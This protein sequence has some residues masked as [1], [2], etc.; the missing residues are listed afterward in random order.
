MQTQT[1]RSDPAGD[2]ASTNSFVNVVIGEAKNLL[3]YLVAWS[4]GPIGANWKNT[5]ANSIDYQVLGGNDLTM[6]DADKKVVASGSI[7]AA[8]TANVEIPVAYYQFYWF[9]QKATAG[10]SQG[11]SRI[12]G[13]FAGV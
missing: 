1:F 10:G 13:R 8:A 5:G 4:S 11:A 12:F 2:P 7:A 6:A 9:Q 3:A